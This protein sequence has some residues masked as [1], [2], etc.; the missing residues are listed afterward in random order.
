MDVQGKPKIKR[1]DGEGSQHE[2][3]LQITK[4]LD[5]ANESEIKNLEEVIRIASNK[6]VQDQ[7]IMSTSMKMAP[8][9]TMAQQRKSISVYESVHSSQG[10]IYAQDY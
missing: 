4:S 2:E 7:Q 3:T 5:R 8:D 6:Q 9:Y 1:R 10:L